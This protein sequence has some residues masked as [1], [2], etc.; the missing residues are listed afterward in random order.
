MRGPWSIT[1]RWCTTGWAWC[2]TDVMIAHPQW[3]T[4][5]AA[6]ASRSVANLGRKIPMNQSCQCNHQ[7]EWNHLN[8]GGIQQ[9][10]WGQNG[11]HWVIPSGIPLPTVTALEEDQQRRCHLPTHTTHHLLSCSTWLGSHLQ[12]LKTKFKVVNKNNNNIG[13]STLDN[14]NKNCNHN[15]GDCYIVLI[16]MQVD[17]MQ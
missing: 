1:Y 14:T 11:L 16:R 6:M 7:K 13:S 17:N 3:L 9:R 5:S 8:R 12:P 2:V 4:L 15:D 10:G